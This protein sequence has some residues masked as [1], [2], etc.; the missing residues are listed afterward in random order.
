MNNKITS[1]VTKKDKTKLF[2]TIS[3]LLQELGKSFLYEISNAT[4]LKDCLVS[5]VSQHEIFF[6]QNDIFW[7][8]SLHLYL[9]S[10]WI[11][12]FKVKVGN[13]M[14]SSKLFWYFDYMY[15][16]NISWCIVDFNQIED[17]WYWVLFVLSLNIIDQKIN[18]SVLVNKFFSFQIVINTFHKHKKNGLGKATLE[19]K[20]HAC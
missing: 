18:T 15:L 4:D 11:D 19:P 12:I 7:S 8:K 20:K 5:Y 16:F 9:M 3:M 13:K 1:K 6:L 10:W 2:D 17:S 14:T